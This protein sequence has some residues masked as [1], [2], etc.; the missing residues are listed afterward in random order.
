[1]LFPIQRYVNA[2]SETVIA[3]RAGK[4][5][6]NP[7][8]ASGRSPSLVTM[9]GIVGVPWQDLATDATRTVTAQLALMSFDEFTAGGRWDVM[10]GDPTA[11]PPIPPT[12]PF[13]VESIQARSGTNPVT[14]QPIM[15]P[16][17]TN[18]AATINGHEYNVN[19]NTL[20]DLQY[21]CIFELPSTMSRDCTSG[22]F[23]SS[24]PTTRRSC[25]CKTSATDNVVDRNR[26]LCQP[27][28]G[29]PAG[30][31]QYFAKAYP[32]SRHLELLKRL[33]PRGVVGS[34]CPKDTT[35]DQNASGYGYN[36][37]MDATV[38]RLRES[39]E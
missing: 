35:G 25:D 11:S 24:D 8:F 3:N 34:I 4:P 33:G 27:P 18:P 19:P 22:A 14:G 38:A 7:L 21:A 16:D 28:S 20:D 5:V 17:S 29:G 12:D 1:L 31:Q 37:V 32:G 6:P 23:T 36:A 2:L 39:L 15:A 10:L 26:P 30:T 9:V 13:M